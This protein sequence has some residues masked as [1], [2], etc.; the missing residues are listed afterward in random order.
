MTSKRIISVSLLLALILTGACAVTP[1]SD[2][3]SSYDRVMQAWINVHHPGLKPYGEYGAYV[4]EM[5]PGTGQSVTDS[6]YVWVH[7]AKRTLDGA[8]SGT[9]IQALA[10]QLGDYSNANWYGSNIWRVD[11]GYIP[12]GLE[13]VIKT[14]RTGGSV[15]IALPYTA[16]THDYSLY[17]AFNSTQELDNMIFDVTLDT[18]VT[19]MYDYQERV[20]RE[21]FKEHYGRTDTLHAGM[22]LQ[23]LVEKTSDTDTFA[24]GNSVKVRYVGRLMNGQVFD[25]NIEDTAKFYRIWDSN[26]SYEALSFQYYKESEDK[27][28]SENSYVTGF[29]QALL[30][31]NYEEVAVTLFNSELGYGD[32]GRSPSIPEYSPLIFWLYIEP[33]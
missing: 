4:L 13:E 24:E 8:I 6:S 20:M 21:W 27:V 23:K 17:D 33:R 7:Y 11:K 32:D 25:T 31:M 18:V 16:S 1:D 29:S 14:L 30:A 19:D 26:G 5:D 28:S 10:E 12:N 2:T 9:N 15:R 3:A 22:Y